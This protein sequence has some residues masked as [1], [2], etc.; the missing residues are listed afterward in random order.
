MWNVRS[1]Q[2]LD[3]RIVFLRPISIRLQI[4][5][6][7]T[8]G[9]S[10]GFRLAP[11][12]ECSETCASSTDPRAEISVASFKEGSSEGC[13]AGK[14]NPHDGKDGKHNKPNNSLTSTRC[15]SFCCLLP[16][17]ENQIHHQ[18]NNSHAHGIDRLVAIQRV[19]AKP[20]DDCNNDNDGAAEQTHMS[21]HSSDCRLERRSSE[22]KCSRRKDA[23]EP[24]RKVSI[25]SSLE[26]SREGKE[27]RADK[28]PQ[29][30][31]LIGN[32]AVG[33]VKIL[34]ASHDHH[35]ETQ[36]HGCRGNRNS[37]VAIALFL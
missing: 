28:V 25:S 29:K 12:S 27:T 2:Y 30:Y 36:A 26:R 15:S 1:E 35:E 33:G 21:T 16:K 3:R 5:I 9:Q 18:R 14:H 8:L 7:L 11:R 23:D 4:L 19:L 34:L 20:G 37:I 22:S 17:R 13:K 6:L 10:L 24:R 32:L 31:D